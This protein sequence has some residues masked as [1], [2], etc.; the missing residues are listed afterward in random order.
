MKG[1]PHVHMPVWAV[2]PTCLACGVPLL[3]VVIVMSMIQMFHVGCYHCCSHWPAQFGITGN[4]PKTPETS[5]CAAYL[6]TTPGN[7]VF[8][9]GRRQYTWSQPGLSLSL[10]LSR[11]LTARDEAGHLM[12]PQVI[13]PELYSRCIHAFYSILSKD[14]PASSQGICVYLVLFPTKRVLGSLRQPA[15]PAWL[16]EHHRWPPPWLKTTLRTMEKGR[17]VVTSLIPLIDVACLKNLLT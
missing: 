5:S 10:R 17:K 2:F 11:T 13:Q 1:F 6:S 8:P 16:R 14:R 12:S 9:Q 4:K 3:S 15:S 7:R